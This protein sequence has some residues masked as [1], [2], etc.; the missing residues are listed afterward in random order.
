MFK[1]GLGVELNKNFSL[2]A[3]YTNLGALKSDG[4]TTGPIAAYK[5]EIRTAGIE[6]VAI[7][8]HVLSEDT[9]IFAKV[10]VYAWESDLE[11]W[12]TSNGQTAT[13]TDSAEGTDITFGAGLEYKAWRF[14]YQRY[15]LSDTDVDTFQ[16]SYL[17]NL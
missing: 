3:A 6:A 5:F 11:T 13:I 10:G 7:G 17:F 8:K 9:R 4:V 16:V 1:L 2:E 14:E 12:A 15:S